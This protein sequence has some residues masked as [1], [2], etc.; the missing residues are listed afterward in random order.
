MIK[1][2]NDNGAYES[3][4]KLVTFPSDVIVDNQHRSG[5]PDMWIQPGS[6][7][8]PPHPQPPHSLQ[9][10]DL[11]MIFHPVRSL[12]DPA[13]HRKCITFLKLDVSGVCGTE[14]TLLGPRTPTHTDEYRCSFIIKRYLQVQLKVPYVA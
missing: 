12:F 2:R 7:V 6:M 4:R 8:K 5:L 1:I 13:N 11:P 3:V 10:Q 9:E 14:I